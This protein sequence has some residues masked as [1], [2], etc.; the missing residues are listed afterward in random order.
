[1]KPQ[2][3]AEQRA[4]QVHERTRE[5]AQERHA[6]V[7]RSP[8]RDR[9]Q[10]AQLPDIFAGA[11]GEVE[12]VERAARRRERAVEHG[13]GGVVVGE[14]AEP[15]RRPEQ[16]RA[17]REHHSYRC[18]VERRSRSRMRH[19]LITHRRG[20]AVKAFAPPHKSK[21]VDRRRSTPP[22]RA[23]ACCDQNR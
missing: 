1:M 23:D 4:I 17:Q 9:A 12:Q 11:V 20:D 2:C 22:S 3:V 21:G 16:V 14:H 19:A 7:V 13:G 8:P 10:P 5:R 15:Q 6:E 18:G